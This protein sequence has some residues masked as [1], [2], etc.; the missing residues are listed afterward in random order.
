M[1]E[2]ILASTSVYRRSLLERLGITFTALPPE[3][4]EDA[5]SGELPPDRALRLETAKAQAIAW[6]GP[7]GAESAA[8]VVL[9]SR[10]A[11]TTGRRRKGECHRGDQRIK[12][13]LDRPSL[14][15]TRA[16]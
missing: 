8:P 3:T 10:T 4:P 5:L 2:L 13:P 9:G 12:S 14:L 16:P 6:V 15:T 1:P 7:T 11:C